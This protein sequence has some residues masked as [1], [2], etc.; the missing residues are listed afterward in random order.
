MKNTKIISRFFG[1]AL[2]LVMLVSSF[3]MLAVGSSASTLPEAMEAKEVY[4]SASRDIFSE[5]GVTFDDY[6]SS[7]GAKGYLNTYVGIFPTLSNGA[8]ITDRV[9]MK[10]Q[11]DGDYALNISGDGQVYVNGNVGDAK[12]EEKYAANA[13]LLDLFN[14]PSFAKKFSISMELT[15]NGTSGQVG[16][17]G[18]TSDGTKTNLSTYYRGTSAISVNGRWLFKMTSANIPAYEYDGSTTIAG[19][20]ANYVKLGDKPV[21][22]DDMYDKG[23]IYP[24]SGVTSLAAKD[25]SDPFTAYAAHGTNAGYD[26]SNS[27]TGAC[28]TPEMMDMDGTGDALTYT[29]NKPF[30]VKLDITKGTDNKATVDVYI[31]DTK[32][33]Q[34][35]Y[36]MGGEGAWKNGIRFFDA[37][38]NVDIDNI[39]VEIADENPPHL[40]TGA[41]KDYERYDTFADGTNG[42]VVITEKCNGCGEV[43]SSTYSNVAYTGVGSA[44]V[45]IN[46][47]YKEG[48]NGS[49]L[50]ST[51]TATRRV[52]FENISGVWND[53][54]QGKFSIN[55]DLV[56]ITALAKDN[57]QKGDGR[58][59]VTWLVK[60]D[61]FNQFFRLFANGEIRLRNTTDNKFIPVDS[62]FRLKVG[63][64]YRF[65]IIV[66]PLN[67]RY[68]VYYD[69]LKDN[70]PVQYFG[71]ESLSAMS[72]Y[73]RMAS[74]YPQVR[75]NDS[76]T[77]T[78]RVANFSVTS[79]VEASEH[80]HTVAY[81]GADEK[82]V[83]VGYDTLKPGLNCYCGEAIPQ[84]NATEVLVKTN[85][86]YYGNATINNIPTEGEFWIAT[87]V[88]VRSKAALAELEASNVLTL[89]E[90]SIASDSLSAPAT[91]QYALKI[92]YVDDVKANVEV[93]VGGK[94]V[95]EHKGVELGD[96]LT[97]GSTESTDVR[98]NVTKIVKVGT[99][100]PVLVPYN[101][102][103]DDS[104][105]PCYHE[106]GDSKVEF[107]TLP[108]KTYE[109]GN[110][111]AIKKLALYYSCPK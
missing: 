78:C 6:D 50:T 46:G 94:L 73:N 92:S 64:E 8:S 10:K 41:W 20:K 26:W 28:I 40:H 81:S 49:G 33:W 56:D 55:F 74:G 19:V 103:T 21:E 63:G 77:S 51:P 110:I 70:E 14:D 57:G 66:D 52:Y 32:L 84:G 16:N 30:I 1:A 45:G 98:F 83:V 104:L 100:T 39:K 29:L 23:Y 85:N 75:F 2:V 65:N 27:K 12:S 80:Q 68:D 59:L 105:V 53:I 91:T 36:T 86:V 11:A 18:M 99:G 42:A 109:S 111:K 87:D 88:N 15:A 71:S 58:S 62:D 9:A 43:I 47:G 3:A 93:Y 44:G 101:D 102:A 79:F 54:K 25:A 22:G 90:L 69:D 31:G 37:N 82:A 72:A 5:N 38:C 89:G 7:L 17:I 96:T 106:K 107:V 76:G 4:F 35:K 48:S 60:S 13:L 61:G 34:T 97:L 24:E 67:G 108:G 95:S